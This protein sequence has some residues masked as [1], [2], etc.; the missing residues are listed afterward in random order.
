MAKRGG[1]G[2]LMK[3][4]CALILPGAVA[5][6]AF[7]AGV[8]DVLAEKNV[9]IDRIVA[10]SSGA[11]NGVAFAAGIRSGRPR[12]MTGKL[13]DTWISCGGWHDSLSFNPLHWLTGR[14]L[15]DQRGL[16]KMLTDLVVPCTQSE[17]H[18]VELRIIVSP[19]N[20][21]SGKIGA[22]SATTYEQVLE[23]KGEH[24]DTQEGLAE[25]FEATTAA[26]AFPGLFAPVEVRGLGP[27]IDGGA[28]NNAP[29]SYVLKEGGIDHI[30]MPVPFPSHI[31][32]AAPTRGLSFLNH[33]I[34]IL[35]N[36]RLFRDLKTAHEINED[37][38]D[39][40]RLRD[41]GILNKEQFAAVKGVLEI[42]HVRISEIRPIKTVCGNA[43]SGFFS[44][45][46]RV[47][48]VAEG[49]KAALETLAGITKTEREHAPQ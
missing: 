18:D 4:R 46:D 12:E 19:L 37:V 14:G 44:G 30:Y 10:T 24:F 1:V 26:C 25:I 28:V 21:V 3:S 17:K 27:C 29:V 5:K 33:L 45:K 43:F 42:D 35:I 34:E 32:G 36:E 38:K 40:E 15:S 49:R 16:M 11:L 48:L 8:V 22:S 6:G 23:F 31:L 7:E 47:K 39:L 20:G 9:R 41:E 13:V 2:R